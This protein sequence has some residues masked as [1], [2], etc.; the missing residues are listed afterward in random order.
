MRPSGNR[1]SF[2]WYILVGDYYFYMDLKDYIV[3]AISRGK[4]KSKYGLPERPD[5]DEIVSF[6]E[7]QGFVRIPNKETLVHVANSKNIDVF[8]EGKFG[9]TPGTHSITI[10]RHGDDRIF[11]MYLDV[12]QDFNYNGAMN[13]SEFTYIGGETNLLQYFKD[14]AQF[15]KV[16]N[17][18]YGW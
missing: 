6:L 17:R 4:Q 14:Y 5:H 18:H 9:K 16:V 8:K 13:F 12:P 3:E 11:Q 7:E 15:R 2:F 1:W 10:Y